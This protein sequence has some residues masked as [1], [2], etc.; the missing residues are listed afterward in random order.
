LLAPLLSAAA[1]LAKKAYT[2]TLFTLGFKSQRVVAVIEVLPGLLPLPAVRLKLT[3]F[4]DSV[5]LKEFVS[6]AC[7]VMM[8]APEFL[9]CA[10]AGRTTAQR[11]TASK[12]GSTSWVF[13]FIARVSSRLEPNS[14]RT[15]APAPALGPTFIAMNYSACA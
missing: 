1:E 10:A 2:R 7:K 15:G 12:T 8:L 4:A 11:R 9:T 3:A 13:R 14:S 5:T 6:T